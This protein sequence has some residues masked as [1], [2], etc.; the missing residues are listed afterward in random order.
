MAALGTSSAKP[1]KRGFVTSLASSVLEWLLILFLLVNAILSL[2]VLKFARYCKL[3]TL[4]F[5]C[6]RLHHVFASEKLAYHWDLIYRNLKSENASLGLCIA[7]NE[8]SEVWGKCEICLFSLLVE[9]T[10]CCFDQDPFFEGHKI[11]CSSSRHCCHC[12][13]PWGFKGYSQ[14]SIQNKSFGWECAELDVPLSSVVGVNQDDLKMGCTH[15]KASSDTGSEVL[16][17]HEDASASLCETDVSEA[18]FTVRGAQLETL[19]LSPADDPGTK[20]L[21][22]ADPPLRDFPLMSRAQLDPIATYGRSF[23]APTVAVENCLE[24]INWQQVNGKASSP[25]SAESDSKANSLAVNYLSS[26][27]DVIPSSNAMETASEVW[28]ESCKFRSFHFSSL[29]E[30]WTLQK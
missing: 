2:L 28:K 30:W 13:E 14:K 18:D 26:L 27:D 10:R 5:L 4:C 6:S 24:E 25:A 1:Q 17:C 3:Q 9:D 29:S 20:K 16:H 8:L 21:I 19:I 23:V 11:G 15:L 22:I 12:N 7:H